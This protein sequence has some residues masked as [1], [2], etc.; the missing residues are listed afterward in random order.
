MKTEEYFF[1]INMLER[2]N[3]SLPLS[4]SS[5]SLPANP[6]LVNEIAFEGSTSTLC[7]VLCPHRG[8]VKKDI[9]SLPE[10]EEWIGSL[11]EKEDIGS[12]PEKE[13]WIG[14]LPEKEDIGSLPEKE[15]WIGS[16]PEKEDI[17]SLPEKEDIGSLPE[18]EEYSGSLPEAFEGSTSTLCRVL[19]PH[20][21]VVKK[22][23]GSLPEKEEWIGSLPEKEDIGSLPEKEEWIGSLPEKEDIGSLPEKEEWSGSLPEKEDIGSLPEKEEYS[24][25]LPEVGRLCKGFSALL[26]EQKER[27]Y[28]GVVQCMEWE[29]PGSGPPPSSD[30]LDWKYLLASHEKVSQ[31]P[32]LNVS[33]KETNMKLSEANS[34]WID[35]IL[36]RGKAKWLT[37]SDDDLKFLYSKINH[38]GN[39]NLI[40]SISSNGATF[41]SPSEVNKAFIKHFEELFS[42][43]LQTTNY[44]KVKW[45]RTGST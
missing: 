39:T 28:S 41:N 42:K 40:R 35:W 36:Q 7:R 8:V 29:T 18:K 37:S 27:H 33:L 1:S 45:I 13:E 16:L 17:G 14:S 43:P 31:D 5:S 23:I 44:V 10:K 25:S 3:P 11:P 6:R 19:C 20:R 26:W 21:G 12:L 22:D 30:L 38:R 15:E 32:E 2:P 24:G 34:R 4:S 9:G